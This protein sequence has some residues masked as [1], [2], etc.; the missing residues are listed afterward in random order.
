MAKLFSAI[1]L[2]LFLCGI[3]F[4]DEAIKDGVKKEYYPNGKLKS[5]AK[6]KNGKENGFKR[7]YAEDGLLLTEI[8]YED[9]VWRD[10]KDYFEGGKIVHHSTNSKDGIFHG[11]NYYANG[12]MMQ[13]Y[14]DHNNRNIF[15]REYYPSGKLAAEILYNKNGKETETAYDEQGNVIKDGLRVEYHPVTMMPIG[16]TPYKDGKRNGVAVISLS[17][18][19]DK[20]KLE[21]VFKDGKVVEERNYNK[22]GHLI[23]KP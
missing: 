16:Q 15:M 19:E 8:I 18:G 12:Q 14:E 23:K 21:Q 4:A 6:Y 3:G 10:H 2:S 13:D 5:E 22:D 17:G 1:V 7:E 9:G 20:S 11:T